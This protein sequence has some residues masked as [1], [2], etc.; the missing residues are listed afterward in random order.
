MKAAGLKARPKR[1]FR[2][3]TTDSHHPHPIAPNRLKTVGISRIAI[4]LKWED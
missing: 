2:P 1:A 3:R 4:P